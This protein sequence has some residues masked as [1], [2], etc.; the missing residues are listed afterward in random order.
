MGLRKDLQ[1]KI[2]VLGISVAKLARLADL[3]QDT[4][5]GFL[6][7]DTQMTAANLDKIIKVLDNYE[8]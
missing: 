5:Y 4:I 6:N 7:G 8:N 2:D 1:K 3:H